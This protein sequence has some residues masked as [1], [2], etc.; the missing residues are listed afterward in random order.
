MAEKAQNADFRRKPQILADSA[1]LLEIQEFGEETADFRR[2]P[3]IFA[4][5]RRKPQIGLRHLRCVTLR[6]A[7]MKKR[8]IK[9]LLKNRPRLKSEKKRVSWQK[10]SGVLGGPRDGGLFRR[11]PW[12]LFMFMVSFLVQKMVPE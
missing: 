6:S 3:K 5:N 11:T 2:K 8:G 12:K 1:L 4:E 9:R 7:L 10:N